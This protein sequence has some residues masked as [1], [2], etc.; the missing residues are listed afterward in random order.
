MPVAREKLTEGEHAA[1]ADA[2]AAALTS[3]A[4]DALSRLNLEMTLMKWPADFREIMWGTVAAIAAERRDEA[5]RSKLSEERKA[6]AQADEA[7]R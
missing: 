2:L 5:G 3:K 7:E 1:K 4:E 6:S